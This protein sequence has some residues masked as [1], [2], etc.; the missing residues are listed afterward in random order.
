MRD[1]TSFRPIPATCTQPSKSVPC[2]GGHEAPTAKEICTTTPSQN[3]SSY[4]YCTLWNDSTS[5]CGIA[6]IEIEGLQ[7]QTVIFAAQHAP[8]V[9]N[10]TSILGYAF[11]LYAAS[12]AGCQ[13]ALYDGEAPPDQPAFSIAV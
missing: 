4:Y 2:S 13:A 5:I 6:S 11:T 3:R 12:F 9:D 1:L 8:P 10:G 7:G